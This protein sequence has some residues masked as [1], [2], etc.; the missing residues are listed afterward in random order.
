M[1][2]YFAASMSVVARDALLRQLRPLV[3]GR[4]EIDAVQLLL[5]F[6]QTAFAYQTDNEQFGRDKPFF[7]DETV[8]YAFSDCED[9][10]V[11]FA[12]LVHTLLDKEVIG[13]A[14][15]NHVATAV[16][17]RGGV[18]GAMVRYRDMDFVVADPTYVNADVGMVMPQFKDARPQVIFATSR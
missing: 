9:R 10:A 14:Y 11:L 18:R 4:D 12:Y 5:R 13:L 1:D 17:M 8:F 6:V 3:E 15:P 7:P 2:A 16:S